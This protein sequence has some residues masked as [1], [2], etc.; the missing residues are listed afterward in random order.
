M[1]DKQK[2]KQ[3]LSR[4][5]SVAPM[6]AWT[7]RHCRYFHRLISPSTLLYTVMIT[8]GALKFGDVPFHLNY[9]DPQEHPLALQL[10]GSDPKEMAEAA[11][12]GEEWGYD[13]ININCGCPSP[14]VQKGAFGA[15]LMGTPDLVANCV[16]AMQQEIETEVTVKTRIGIDE[17]DSYQFLTDFV[18]K[19]YEAGCKSFTIHARKAWLNGLSPKENRDIP[20]LDYERVYQLKRDFP[21]LEIII[22]GGIKTLPEIQTHLNHCDG[23]MV[24]REAYHNPWLLYEVEKTIFNN[25]QHIKTKREIAEEMMHYAQ[26][27]ID[28]GIKL[29]D[30]TK[31]MLGLYQNCPGA[32]IW[33]QMLS[34]DAQKNPKDYT[35][36]TTAADIVEDM[37]EKK[38]LAA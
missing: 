13:E 23:V 18:G 12:L 11:K 24:G 35:L 16:K 7:D 20:P 21:A 26:T 33:R 32:K 5:F 29:T 14:R 3:D 37:I 1:T 31:H 30:I 27:Q 17:Q 38:R 10:G 6:M 28:L 4:I 34:V 19:S 22:N 25:Q 8:S 9:N 2:S 36:I 15:C